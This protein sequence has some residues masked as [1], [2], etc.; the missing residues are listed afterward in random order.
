M[1]DKQPTAEPVKSNLPKPDAQTVANSK[2]LKE[3]DTAETKG[4]PT[5]TVLEPGIPDTLSNADTKKKN[6]KKS[7]PL[8]YI[9]S[10]S[11]RPYIDGTMENM[12][13]ENYGFVLFPGT[14]QEEQLAA[15]ERNGITRYITGLNEFAPEVQNLNDE[16]KKLAIIQNIRLIVSDLEKKLAANVIDVK[17][18]EFWNKV[19]LLKPDNDEFWAKISLKCSNEPT[20]LNPKEDPYDLI[21]F[22]AIEAGGFDIVAKSYEDAQT[23]AR[24][25][26]FYLDKEV[27]TVST[28]TQQRKLK[29]KAI[30]LLD[31]LSTSNPRKLFYVTKCI[32]TYSA[33]YKNATP[34]DILYE[35]MDEFINGE[36]V[37][38]SEKKAADLFIRTC[39]LDM[40]TLKIK[41]VVKDASFYNFIQLKGDGMLYHTATGS[42]LG[43]NVTDVVEA[44]KNPLNDEVLG[45][46]LTEVEEYWNQ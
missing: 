34:S 3:G 16:E 12:G 8:D 30:A 4:S 32:D 33:R 36:G 20:F 35:S 1:S 31:S 17:D 19:T 26:K 11:I 14:A 18:D 23:R 15:I 41:A 13:L 37:E 21:K 25:P 38:R 43:R 22:M 39:D 2:K 44:L 45:R 42:M 7:K 6:V 10:I 9:G 29:N 28:R 24:P 27:D 46:L 40:E 5:T